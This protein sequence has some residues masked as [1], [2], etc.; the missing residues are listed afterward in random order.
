MA[1]C[2]AFHAL[3]QPLLVGHSNKGFL[4]KLM[5]NLDADRTFVTAGAAAALAAQGVQVLRVHN[6]AAVRQTLLGFAAA[7]GLPS[8]QP[9]PFP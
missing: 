9:G 2:H 8:P 4:G 6:V 3:G 1:G 5:N 7:G